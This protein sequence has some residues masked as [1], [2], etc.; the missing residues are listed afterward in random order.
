VVVRAAG[1]VVALAALF[2]VRLAAVSPAPLSQ[3]ARVQSVRARSRFPNIRCMARRVYS[4]ADR[5]T[6]KRQAPERQPAADSE[7]A[8]CREREVDGVTADREAANCREREVRARAAA[9]PGRI[10]S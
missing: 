5:R 7:R 4:A 8:N 6:A 2:V 3:V 9:A 10:G 1:A